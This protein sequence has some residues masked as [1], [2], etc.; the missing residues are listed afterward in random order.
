MADERV[1]MPLRL[2]KLAF[3]SLSIDEKF[4]KPGVK[5]WLYQPGSL[6]E[7]AAYAFRRSEMISKELKSRRAWDA[8]P[9]NGNEWVEC[10]D[11]RRVAAEHGLTTLELM[12]FASIG[13]LGS[14]N[15]E[16][17]I[18]RLVCIAQKYRKEGKTY[19]ESLQNAV[20]EMTSH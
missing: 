14:E 17:F 8:M 10:K 7:W 11:M 15:F 19:L 13:V 5:D 6:K 18:K 4:P 2:T 16:A 9:G 1:F 12:P 3:L 20:K